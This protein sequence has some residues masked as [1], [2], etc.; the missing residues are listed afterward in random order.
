MKQIDYINP[1][2]VETVTSHHFAFGDLDNDGDLDMVIGEYHGKLIFYRNIG[3]RTEPVWQQELGMFDDI[4][5]PPISGPPYSSP[6]LA[7][8]DSDGDLDL[9]IGVHGSS[10]LNDIYFYRNTGNPSVPDWQEDKNVIQIS[11]GEMAIPVLVDLDNDQDLDMVIG[12]IDGSLH[13]YRNVGDKFTPAWVEEVA[14]FLTPTYIDVG[15][16]SSPSLADLD[17][18]GDFDLV[19]GALDGTLTYFENVGTANDP[20]FEQQEG[21]FTNIDVGSNCSPTLVDLDGDNDYD[22]VLGNWEKNVVYYENTGTSTQPTWLLQEEMFAGIDVGL[23]SA[24]A[25]C[26]LNGDG[27][28]DLVI[29][30]KQSSMVQPIYLFLNMGT[31]ENPVWVL[32][33]TGFHEVND[34]VEKYV[35][36]TFADLD[37]DGDNDLITGSWDGRLY[38]FEN[39]GAISSPVWTY[40]PY[41]FLGIDVGNYCVPFLADLDGDEDLDLTIGE[42]NGRLTF[43]RNFGTREI[44]Q[45]ATEEVD[46]TIYQNIDVGN[47]SAPAL[48][49]IDS[50]DDLDLIIGISTGSLV[51]YEN[52]GNKYQPAWGL[53]DFFFQELDF[54]LDWFPIPKVYDLNQDGKDDL[55][56]VEQSGTVKV[57]WNN[58]SD[59]G[60]KGPSFNNFQPDFVYDTTFFYISGIISDLDGV[61]DDNTGS[62]G[63]GVYLLWDNDGELINSANEIQMNGVAG[64]TFRTITMISSQFRDAEFVY[65]VHA[66]DNHPVQKNSGESP[67][68]QI[69]VFDDDNEGPVFL[70]FNPDTVEAGETFS[71]EAGVSDPSG[72]FDDMTT[73]DGQGA[74]LRWDTDGEL[75]NTYHEIP[76]SFIANDLLQ[77]DEPL[78]GQTEG[79][80]VYYQIYLYDNDF[81]NFYLQDRKQSISTVQQVYIRSSNPGDDDNQGPT[82]SDIVTVPAQ[83][84]DTTSFH[85]EAKIVDSSGVYDDQTGS[86]GQGVHVRW[87]IDGELANNFFETQMS[88]IGDD[89]F[90]TDEKIPSQFWGSDLIYR[91]YAYDNDFDNENP[92]DRTQGT[93]LVQSIHINDDDVDPPVFSNFSPYQAEP[94]NEFF[95]ECDITD[96]SGIYDDNTGS[97][98]FGV[99][100]LWDTDGEL[101]NSANELQMDSVSVNH[102][103]TVFALNGLNYTDNFVYQVYAY[104]NDFDNFYSDDRKQGKSEAIE[105]QLSNPEFELVKFGMAPNPFEDKTYFIFEL[106]KDAVIDI[107]VFTVSGER[108]TQIEDNYRAGNPAEIEWDGS[109]IVGENLASGVYVIRFQAKSGGEKIERTEKIAIIR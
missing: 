28:P 92:M 88:L 7:D 33:N 93:S 39:T 99:Y 37:N 42:E 16:R 26:D 100:L 50:D 18:D 45:F 8:I 2:S 21:M 17:G 81:D 73:S 43:Y 47:R 64:D 48:M 38:F 41:M 67:L 60:M 40:R 97:D 34:I 56:L 54:D 58:L 107:Q 49:D 86:Q 103:R 3:T 13:Y 77:T 63:Q 35:T 76:L 108:V 65:Q 1:S 80:I 90:R 72:C 4:D 70:F 27:L 59:G 61:Y 30:H 106:S 20:F 78:S 19:V 15:S 6:D 10:T 85:I 104:D 14:F 75:S 71:I 32:D 68:F 31:A 98:G 101:E 46:T 69:S 89:I 29:G 11:E 87:D 84:Y 96:T 102:F 74:F 23:N 12:D 52:G 25:M 9:I 94:G 66:F 91:I 53:R 95:I 79:T 57:Y 22:L 44:P 51:L 109:N 62:E 82:I 105:I 5:I 55:I 24:P 83:V 36:P